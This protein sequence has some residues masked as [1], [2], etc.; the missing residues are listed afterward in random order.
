MRGLKN[1]RVAPGSL[2]TLMANA[3]SSLPPGGF[4]ANVEWAQ[5]HVV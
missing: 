2:I 4:Q 1:P 5:E 3:Q